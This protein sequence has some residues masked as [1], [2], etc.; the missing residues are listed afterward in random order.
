MTGVVLGAFLGSKALVRARVPLLRKVFAVVI[1]F[2]A[3][4]MIYNGM[5]GRL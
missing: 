4:E 2:I 1:F 3:I 5:T